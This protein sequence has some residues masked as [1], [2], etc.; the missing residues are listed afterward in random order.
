MNAEQHPGPENA[1]LQE[2]MA[3]LNR[4]HQRQVTS[5]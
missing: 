2:F 3:Q 1:E 5:R 4:Q